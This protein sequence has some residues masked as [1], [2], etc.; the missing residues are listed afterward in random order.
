MKRETKF[1][2]REGRAMRTETKFY[3]LENEFYCW[4]TKFPTPLRWIFNPAEL[5]K[6]V[7][8]VSLFRL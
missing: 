8:F 4:D 6:I 2:A 3:A 7:T 5:Y 1:Y